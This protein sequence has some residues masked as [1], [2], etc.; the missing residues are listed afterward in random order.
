[1][2]PPGKY[3]LITQKLV[4]H[5]CTSDESSFANQPNFNLN[6]K[7]LHIIWKLQFKINVAKT[8]KLGHQELSCD[9][10]QSNPFPTIQ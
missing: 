8:R 6:C 7:L 10:Y 1:M 2:A 5:T 3:W 9:N 4:D